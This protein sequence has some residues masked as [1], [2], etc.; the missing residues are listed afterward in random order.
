[1][2]VVEQVQVVHNMAWW[3][4][5]VIWL[6][7]LAAKALRMSRKGAMA[8]PGACIEATDYTGPVSTCMIP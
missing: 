3:N 7:H 4:N 1:V 8:I 6:T 2:T 5:I